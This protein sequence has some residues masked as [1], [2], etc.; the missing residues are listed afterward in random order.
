MELISFQPKWNCPEKYR[1]EANLSEFFWFD[2]FKHPAFDFTKFSCHD[3]VMNVIN[4]GAPYVLI[5][6]KRFYNNLVPSMEK[7]IEVFK[8]DFN[9]DFSPALFKVE[10][11]D[12][13]YMDLQKTNAI[14]NSIKKRDTDCIYIYYYL[15][16]KLFR[17]IRREEPLTTHV[18]KELL[19]Y[20]KQHLYFAYGFTNTGV[21]Y[22]DGKQYV[23]IPNENRLLSI[24]KPFGFPIGR[25]FFIPEDSVPHLCFYR[26]P[27]NNAISI[28][29]FYSRMIITNDDTGTSTTYDLNC[30][31]YEQIKEVFSNKNLTV[32]GIYNGIVKVRE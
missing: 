2:N 17:S 21:L 12:M 14:L 32:T 22:K 31:N 13:I 25:H 26:N 28:L 24:F 6:E 5:F 19:N 11:D 23:G 15:F 20:M 10:D 27:V 30:N 1:G 7:A 4:Y 16:F 8:N 9:I 29:Y 18:P 3:Y